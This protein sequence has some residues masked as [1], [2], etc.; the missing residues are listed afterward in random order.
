[1]LIDHLQE[2]D[3]FERENQE[4]QSKLER[5]DVLRDDEAKRDLHSFTHYV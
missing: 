3:A 4:L 1:V 5:Q 2:L